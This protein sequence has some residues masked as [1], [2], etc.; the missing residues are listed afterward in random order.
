MAAADHELHCYM[1]LMQVLTGILTV[2]V[3]Q[4]HIEILPQTVFRHR[5]YA[6]CCRIVGCLLIWRWI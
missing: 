5:V 3:Q 1:A 2:H 6:Q 4:L